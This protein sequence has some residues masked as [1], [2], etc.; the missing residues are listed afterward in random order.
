MVI[1]ES[2]LANT[3]IIAPNIGMAEKVSADIGMLYVPRDPFDLTGK[4]SEALTIDTKQYNLKK[5]TELGDIQSYENLYLN[6]S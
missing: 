6:V 4:L 5:H 2:I 3:P 1:Q